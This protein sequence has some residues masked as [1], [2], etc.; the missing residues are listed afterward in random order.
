MIWMWAL[1]IGS[2]GAWGA[3]RFCRDMA[4]PVA[5]Y[6]QVWT[7]SV[8]LFLAG[9]VTYL[10]VDAALWWALVLSGFGFLLG[11][12]SALI[13]G[14]PKWRNLPPSQEISV[15]VDEARLRVLLQWFTF[16]GAVGLLLQIRHLQTTMGLDLLIEDPVVARRL[17][18][19][20]PVWG[21]FNLLNVA[22]IP[23]VVIYVRVSG[24]FRKWMS[25]TI[26]LAVAAA[27][28][29]TDRTRFFYMVIWTFFVWIYLPGRR[30][31]PG[32]KWLG[33]GFV[34]VLLLVFFTVIGEHYDRKYRDRFPEHIHLTGRF[35]V[36]IEPYIYLTGSLAALDALLNDEN[37]MYKGKFSF[38]PLVSL[39]QVFF[40]E[41]ETVQLQ[42]KLYFVP[43]EINTY[44]Y[45][46]QFY[47]DFGWWGILFGPYVCGWLTAW[48][49]TLMRR[50]PTLWRVYTAGLLTFCCVMSVFVNTFTQEATWFFV[51]LGFGAHVWVKR[52]DLSPENP[53][54]GP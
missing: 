53:G 42:G 30:L 16:L 19:N 35:Q 41:I 21:Y 5:V 7:L 29:T 27:L 11:G 10:P 44:S 23:L 52:G 24:R 17:H 33:L 4:N 32:R 38:S 2:F 34:V 9:W 8:A 22:N 39:A 26:L 13:W 40:P 46:Q 36:L 18:S 49:Y 47:Q 14:T 45:L 50:K 1:L 20:V 37:P 12:W 48:V 54:R 28:I 51:L 43:M 15:S 25:L 31:T 3:T 6:T